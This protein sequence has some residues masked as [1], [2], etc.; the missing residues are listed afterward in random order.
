MLNRLCMLSLLMVIHM[1]CLPVYADQYDD[2]LHDCSQKLAPCV[3][4]A[5]LTAGNVQEEQDLVAAC[6]KNKE[7]CIKVCRDAEVQ[8]QPQSQPQPVPQPSHQE[9]K[10]T[11][12]SGGIKT[13]DG[14]SSGIKTYEFK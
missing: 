9:N 12:N 2:C 1:F 13:Y 7:E 8:S 10:G 6:D 4:Q 5:H 14:S 3:E 11:E